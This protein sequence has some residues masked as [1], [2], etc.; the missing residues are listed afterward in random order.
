MKIAYFDAFSGISGDMTIGA[1]I[2]AGVDFEEFK[3]EV[4]KLN[5]ENFE[6]GVRKVIRHGISATKF[7][8]MVKEQEHRHRHLSDVFQII[9]GSSLSEF[10]KQTS[11]KIFTTLA[12]AEAKIH[13]TTIEEVHFHE[14]GAIDSIVDIVGTSICIEKLGIEKIFVSK[15]PL[16]SGG[17]VQTRHGRMPIPSPATV[18]IL[19]NVPVVLTDVQFELTTPTGA[20]IVATLA[21]FG[22]EKEIIR[23]NSVG[24]GAGEFEI[25]NQPNLLRVIIGE[26]PLK[27][28]EEKL[29]LIETNIDDMN[30]EIYP[31]VIEKLLSAGAKDAYLVPLIM[32]KGRPGILL[33]VLVSESKLDD[34]LNLIFTQTTTLGVRIIE[35]RRKKLPRT[36]KEIDTPFGKV[37]FKLV[38]IDNTERLIPEFEECKRIA[39][40]RNLPLVQ[41][42]KILESLVNQ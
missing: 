31:Y 25:P 19:K 28:E 20:A 39:E 1:F 26:A 32:K 13:N 22:L 30:P 4:Q 38:S 17:F 23:I 42:Y 14:V 11:K 7:D 12:Q 21:E 2:D 40:E 5:L 36:Q 27:Y 15:V 35:I 6:V 3:S 16:G 10:V 37:K 33:S 8:V 41:V 9:D 18:E 24:Y 34:V 29:L